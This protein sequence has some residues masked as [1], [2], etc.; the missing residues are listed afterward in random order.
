MRKRRIAMTAFVFIFAGVIGGIYLLGLPRVEEVYPQKGAG[1]VQA[2]TPLRIRF[3][4]PMQP[5]SVAAKL[6]TAPPT[7][8]DFSWAGNTLVFTP[9]QPWPS[10]QNV[11]VRLEAGAKASGFLPLATIQ[12]TTWEFTI[13]HPLLIYL[14]PSSAPADLYLLDPQ[15]GDIQ[16]LS[17]ASGGVLD[18]SL[19]SKGTSIYYNVSQSDGGSSLYRLDRPSGEVQ[20]LLACPDALC[21]YPQI[22]PDEGFLAYERTALTTPGQLNMPQVWLLPLTLAGEGASVQVGDPVIAAHADHKTQQPQWSPNGLLTYYDYDRSD[23]IVQDVQGRE[24][25]AFPSQTGFPGTWHPGGEYYVIPEIYT[26]EIADT[27]ILTDL[28]EVPTS[29]LLRFKLD[30]SMQDLTEVN[31]VEDSSP[32]YSPDGSVLAFG[33]K[34]LDLTRWTPGRQIW[35]MRADGSQV[36]AITQEPYYNHYDLMWSPDGSR[37]AYVRFNKNSLIEPPEL[38]LMNA[39]GSGATLLITGGYSP[40]W[41]P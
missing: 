33:R 26:S 27:N 37:L 23:F 11:R 32:A 22:S 39:D 30:G 12:A 8:G 2:G 35:Q 16:Q 1:P 20:L 19:N 24:V 40:Q 38:W 21:R 17:D 14:F 6:T 29:H 36:A 31:N 13:G 41:V 9:N 3:S 4:R 18:Y 5:A 10:G 15:N 34:Y 28:E 25:A 7:S